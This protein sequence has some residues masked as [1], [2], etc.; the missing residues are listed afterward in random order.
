MKVEKQEFVWYA[1]HPRDGELVLVCAAG[2]R[3]ALI[4]CTRMVRERLGSKPNA[5]ARFEMMLGPLGFVSRDIYME[6][7]I[8]VPMTPELRF[9][10]ILETRRM[11]DGESMLDASDRHVTDFILREW[12]REMH[13][14]F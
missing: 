9:L 12:N 3:K 10:T 14:K 6:C 7:G 2:G 5:L 4:Y 1:T 11:L 13:K 8:T